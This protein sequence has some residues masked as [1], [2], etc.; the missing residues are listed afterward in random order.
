MGLMQ[1]SQNHD[2]DN[3][4]TCIQ[5]PYFVYLDTINA[6]PQYAAL[7]SNVFSITK[8]QNT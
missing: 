7:F 2:M 5:V 8:Y 6:L 4:T 1:T 3:W